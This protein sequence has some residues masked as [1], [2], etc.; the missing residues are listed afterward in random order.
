[1]Y[2]AGT[3]SGNITDTSPTPGGQYMKVTAEGKSHPIL[4]GIPL[5]SQDR[6]KIIRDPIR[7]R[8]LM[9]PSA[10]R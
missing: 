8:M 2:S 1:M 5:D 3:T 10:A 4:Q 7:K 9:F 6:I